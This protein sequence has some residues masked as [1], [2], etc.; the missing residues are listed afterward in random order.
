VC[1]VLHAASIGDVSLQNS[2]GTTDEYD[3]RRPSVAKDM[4]F[5]CFNSSFSSWTAA[6]IGDDVGVGLRTTCLDK[7]GLRFI[8]L[9][10]APTPW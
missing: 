7:F 5:S 9:R 8:W 10:L 4:W 3:S 2:T 6:V 1:N